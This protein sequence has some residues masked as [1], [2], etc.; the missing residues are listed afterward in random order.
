MRANI[1]FSEKLDLSYLFFLIIFFL[2]EIKGFAYRVNQFSLTKGTIQRGPCSS[3]VNRNSKETAS[4]YMKTISELT[5]RLWTFLTPTGPPF[6]TALPCRLP[7]R[8]SPHVCIK[9]DS[10]VNDWIGIMGE[11]LFNSHFFFLFFHNAQARPA[12]K[13]SL[14][15]SASLATIQR[16]TLALTITSC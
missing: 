4:H 5:T 2:E 8:G 15:D 11:S 1:F 9:V 13:K 6:L 12:K 7:S 10:S 14:R 16:Q 3:A